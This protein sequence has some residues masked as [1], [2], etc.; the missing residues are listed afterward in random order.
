M[1]PTEEREVFNAAFHDVLIRSVQIQIPAILGQ[2]ESVD[3][4]LSQF[5]LS[6][7]SRLSLS[8]DSKERSVAYEAATRVLELVANPTPLV[9]VV[10]LILARLGNFPARSFTEAK[11]GSSNDFAGHTPM[12]LALEEIARGV[13]NTVEIRERE[14]TLTDF[15][16]RLFD[17]LERW[18]S[19]S[20][21]APTSAGKSFLLALDVVRHHVKK[22]RGAIVFVVPT[23]ALI[24]QVMRDVIEQL[25]AF[26]TPDVPVLC[27]PEVPPGDSLESGIVYVLTQ[28][29]L[30][31]LIST[32]EDAIPI[33]LL[34]VDEAQEIGDSGRGIVLQ[35]AVERTISLHPKMRV[36]FASPLRSNP[37]FLL[38]LFG[39]TEQGEFFVERMSPVSQNIVLIS[40]VRRKPEEATLQLL[41]DDERL[42][43]GSVNLPFRFRVEP[44]QTR[45]ELLAHFATTLTQSGD[46]TLVYVNEPSQAETAAEAIR[47]LLPENVDQPERV[48]DLIEFLENNVHPSYP[49]IPCLRR[50]VAFHYGAMP[51]VIRVEVEDLVRD[52]IL[53]FVC[54]TS[55]LLQGVN[56]PAKNVV[57]YR[58]T[59]G[60]GRP[61][62]KGGF[63]NLAGRAG[64]LM[65]EYTG[66]VWCIS[67]GDWEENPLDGDRLVEMKSA[68]QSELQTHAQRVVEAAEDSDRSS[69]NK[70][71]LVADQTYS[72]VFSDFT[73]NDMPVSESSL[74]TDV[75]RPAFEQLD[76]ACEEQKNAA[77]VPEQVF[78]QNA[79]V[80][81]QRIEELAT[82]FR[83]SDPATLIPLHPFQP[84]AYNRLRSILETLEAVFFKTGTQSY[85]YH[86]LLAHRWMTGEPLA[87]MIA[88]AIDHNQ[89]PDDDARRVSRVIRDLLKD[90]QMILR[91]KYVK[92]IR[93][94]CELLNT[95]FA[96]TNNDE[97][98]A[99]ISPLHLYL[100]YGACTD[101][102]IHLMSLGLS[103]TSA[104]GF[105][106]SIGLPS[107]ANW[108]QCR[109][110]VE[111]T[112]LSTVQLPAVVLREISSLR[113]RDN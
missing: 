49:L 102:L 10:E 11:F 67:P 82:R 26:D 90:I 78:R 86:T 73:L 83:A 106:N 62:D 74:C 72:K 35:S 85:I 110:A 109:S 112:S 94:Y 54:C 60:R 22:V 46:S 64:R 24:R 17:A 32:H 69:E 100:E 31:N 33:S 2:P 42:E 80:L 47:E 107:T 81:P 76:Q 38:T 16:R 14:I 30:S 28:E 96:E 57:V 98:S 44:G 7:S 52:G 41:R 4:P 39:R 77:T 93:L 19:V 34:I 43:L 23:R 8:S 68:F 37:G 55:T 45:A 108:E 87:T 59:R 75:N 79:T 95:H 92:Y 105:A 6:A 97:L 58:P 20:V 103:R 18:N 15:Q 104:I 53:Q 99:R 13:E 111:D 12:R 70:D 113:H 91:Y 65:R 27:V 1:L 50:G 40:Q 3:E 56:L 101:S 25:R 9:G 71:T 21:S 48:T 88:G 63:W 61:L 5:L 89:V 36:L 84:N 29:R 66:N 51:E